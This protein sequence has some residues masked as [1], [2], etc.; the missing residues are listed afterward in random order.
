LAE[1]R[2]LAAERGGE[3]LSPRYLGTHRKLNFRCAQ[4]HV[5]STEPMVI[6]RGSWCSQCHRDSS[7][8]RRH[9][10]LD[11]VIKRNGGTLLSEYVNTRTPV[12]LRC[13][14]G[15]EWET[16]V[17]AIIYDGRSCP[18]CNRY[19]IEDMRAFAA[20]RGGDCLSKRYKNV[21]I[22]LRWRCANGHVWRS[23]PETVLEGRWCRRCHGTSTYD[24]EDMRS[25]A[26]ARGGECLTRRT[27][28]VGS[29]QKLEWRC[30]E[31][32]RWEAL[33]S[34]VIQ[35]S[36]CGECAVERWRGHPRTRL[37]I[38]QM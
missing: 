35:G 15:H 22:A 12:R 21:K 33:V 26:R 29:A 17:D 25:L 5:W 23:T 9:E 16:R 37:T 2:N 13:A 31:G 8:L 32:H 14:Q 4:G 6:K 3:V 36:W 11:A 19:T 7:R 38:E 28:S 18:D 30:G 34:N 20:K 24:F 10:Q 1:L 27:G